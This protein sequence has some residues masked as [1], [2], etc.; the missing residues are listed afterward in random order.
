VTRVGESTDHREIADRSGVSHRAG[1]ARSLSFSLSLS[2]SASCRS[3]WNTRALNHSA[4]A[5]GSPGITN[6]PLTSRSGL[7]RR[8]ID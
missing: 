6:D 5:V 8:R 3:R 1:K 7:P 4:D 2:P